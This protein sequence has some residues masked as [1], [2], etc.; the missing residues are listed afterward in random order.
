MPARSRRCPG[1]GRKNNGAGHASRDQTRDLFFRPGAQKTP[2]CPLLTPALLTHAALEIILSRGNRCLS[3]SHEHN[4]R[5]RRVRNPLFRGPT[6]PPHP[7][8]PPP[9][10][11]A[12]RAGPTAQEISRISAQHRR[13]SAI[14]SQS[15]EPAASG[16]GCASAG[17]VWDRSA[18]RLQLAEV[19]DSLCPS[20]W[21]S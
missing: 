20:S 9:I 17:G 16:A 13:A 6:R 8:P 5:G 18:G 15:R 10:G 7:P 3:H 12:A 4:C 21:W 11:S 1:P 2:V 19:V 14:A